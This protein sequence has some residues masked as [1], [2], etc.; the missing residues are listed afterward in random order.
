M[1]TK[2]KK[3]LD[4]YAAELKQEGYRVSRD[5]YGTVTVSD[6]STLDRPADTLGALV[7]DPE[8]GDMNVQ[9]QSGAMIPARVH[10]RFIQVKTEDR[11]KGSKSDEGW[12]NVVFIEG[13]LV[14]D[15]GPDEDGET[16]YR[17]VDA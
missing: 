5:D 1:A 10:G 7:V 2:T 9:H 12:R 8:S 4:E 13:A 3:T 15:H 16:V 17:S 11:V 14:T 6:R